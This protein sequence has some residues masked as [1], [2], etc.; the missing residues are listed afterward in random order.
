[1]ICI[2]PQFIHVHIERKRKKVKGPGSDLGGESAYRTS[3]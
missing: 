1:V 2:V 3:G